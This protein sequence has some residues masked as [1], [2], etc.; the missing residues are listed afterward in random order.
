MMQMWEDEDDDDD[1]EWEAVKPITSPCVTAF[2][3]TGA[4]NFHILQVTEV[5]QIFFY[6]NYFGSGE[7]N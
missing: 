6:N 1:D 7:D 2:W 5:H 3:G 4:K